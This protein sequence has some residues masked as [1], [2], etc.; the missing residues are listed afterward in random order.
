M[1]FNQNPEKLMK[2][3]ESS[4]YHGLIKKFAL[5]KSTWFLQEQTQELVRIQI[6]PKVMAKRK[7]KKKSNSAR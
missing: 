2:Q 4:H 1:M 5:V 3:L 7:K 6:F